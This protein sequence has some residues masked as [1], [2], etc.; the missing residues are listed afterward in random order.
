MPNPTLVDLRVSGYDVFPSIVEI[1]ISFDEGMPI[2][3]VSLTLTGATAVERG[4]AKISRGRF[5]IPTK[6]LALDHNGV[7]PEIGPVTMGLLPGA[8]APTGQVTGQW[9]AE[10]DAPVFPVDSTFHNVAVRVQTAIGAFDLEPAGVS[11]KIGSIPPQGAVYGHPAQLKVLKAGAVV[12]KAL[13]KHIV[14]V[15]AGP[16]QSAAKEPCECCCQ[17]EANGHC[18]R[19]LVRDQDGLREQ[20]LFV[21][22]QPGVPSSPVGRDRV[23]AYET[24]TNE[25]PRA[26]TVYWDGDPPNYETAGQS[27]LLLPNNTITLAVSRSVKVMYSPDPSQG[28]SGDYAQGHDVISWCCP[29][30][31]VSKPEG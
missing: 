19:F 3:N 21:G 22:S 4:A 1:S 30:P 2:S 5:V 9:S 17:V 23:L 7:I 11:A 6:F 25:G 31:W 28:L 27:T 20:L 14:N 29:D 10:Q 24:I 16:A 8:P 12:G 13:A 15:P 26:V 18:S